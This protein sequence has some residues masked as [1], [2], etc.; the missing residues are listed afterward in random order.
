VA[1]S[2]VNKKGQVIECFLGLVRVT[3]TCDLSLKSALESVFAK[4][5]LSLSRI[6]GQGY[7]RASNMLGEFNGLKSLIL[8]ENCSAFYIH[9]FAHQLQLALVSLAKKNIE[10]ASFFNLVGNLSNCWSIM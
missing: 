7:D 6:R 4:H 3:D 9:C 2:Y 1:L 5:G 8:N 10:I